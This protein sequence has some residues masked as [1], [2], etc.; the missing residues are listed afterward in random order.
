[1]K[2]LLD[3]LTLDPCSDP[4]H[5]NADSQRFFVK[6]IFLAHYFLY[7]EN[8]SMLVSAVVNEVCLDLESHFGDNFW[9]GTYMMRWFIK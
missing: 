1:M 4:H 7:R 3:I 5:T 8:L 9:P 2:N 6:K